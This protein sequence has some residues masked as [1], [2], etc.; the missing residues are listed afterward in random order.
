MRIGIFD[1]GIG[2]EAIAR[3]LARAFSDSTIMTVNDRKNVP[4]GSRKAKEI[5]RLTNTAIQPLIS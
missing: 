4:Y 2:G 5:I 3:D 1:S